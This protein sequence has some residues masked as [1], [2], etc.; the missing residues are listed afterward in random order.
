STNRP[1]NS[2]KCEEANRTFTYGPDSTHVR[3]VTHLF[4]QPLTGLVCLPSPKPHRP[5]GGRTASPAVRPGRPDSDASCPLRHIRSPAAPVR[6]RVLGAHRRAGGT[7]G[8]DP[9][10][11]SA[12]A[13]PR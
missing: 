5:R 9:A 6:R 13:A 1:C 3:L 10:P 2:N 11:A 12:P 8:G 7:D 4:L